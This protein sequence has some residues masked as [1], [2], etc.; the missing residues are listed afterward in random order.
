MIKVVIAEDDFFFLTFLESKLM[1]LG[2]YEIIGVSDSV[3]G[4]YNIIR[5]K[6]PDL[7]ITDIHLKDRNSGI[8]LGKLVSERN[9]PI[10]FITE[11]QEKKYYDQSEEIHL[12]SFLVKPFHIHTL[13]SVIQALLTLK[14]SSIYSK[15]L[16]YSSGGVKQII[17]NEDIIYIE[18]EK[19]YCTVYTEK[20][21]YAYKTSLT[22]LIEK[23]NKNWFIRVHKSYLINV[24]KIKSFSISESYFTIGNSTVPIGRTYKKS[25]MEFLGN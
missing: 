22:K 18:A 16:V 13:D 11:S 15:G 20:G 2:G 24:N 19:N 25:I 5:A 21:K 17:S 7:I 3:I 8:E 23:L 4:A 12:S 10:L 6:E 1:E 9:I 14:A